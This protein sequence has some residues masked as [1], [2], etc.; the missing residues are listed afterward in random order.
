MRAPRSWEH[1]IM[2]REV[3][4]GKTLWRAS[5]MMVPIALLSGVGGEELMP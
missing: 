4:F 2:E 5:R 3:A 1:Q